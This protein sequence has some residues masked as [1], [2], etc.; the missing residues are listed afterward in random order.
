VAAIAIE[1]GATELVHVEWPN[2]IVSNMRI[3]P[4]LKNN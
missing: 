4:V 1:E 2:G 3:S